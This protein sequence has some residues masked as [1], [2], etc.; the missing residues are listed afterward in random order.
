MSETQDSIDN[1]KLLTHDDDGAFHHH[2]ETWVDLFAHRQ[3][4]ELIAYTQHTTRRPWMTPTQVASEVGIPERGIGVHLK[5]VVQLEA[6]ETTE[7]HGETKYR[8]TEDSWLTNC[9]HDI[10]AT[11]RANQPD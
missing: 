2:E 7:M 6:F 1:R 10:E 5:T 8:P 3:V 9:F 11:I 4:R